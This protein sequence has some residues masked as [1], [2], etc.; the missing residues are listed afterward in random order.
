MVEV[1]PFAED[2]Q[3]PD[4]GKYG[5]RGFDGPGNGDG[6]MLGGEVGAGPRCEYEG[7][8]AYNIDVFAQGRARYIKERIVHL[9]WEAVGEDNAR[10]KQQA[11]KAGVEEQHGNDGIAV[12]RFLFTYVVTAQ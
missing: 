12:E 4:E 5:L 6:Q 8:F 10:Q 9:F 2:E 3:C 1:E 7:R 11:A